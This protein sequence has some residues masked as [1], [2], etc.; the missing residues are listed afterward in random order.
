MTWIGMPKNPMKHLGF[1]YKIT[2]ISDGKFYIGKKLFWFKKGKK[3][4]PSDWKTYYGSSKDLIADVNEKGKQAFR[5]EVIRCYDTKW[6]LM[7]Y[8]LIEQLKHDVMNN[9]TNTFNG[10]INVRLRKRK[11]GTNPKVSPVLPR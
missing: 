6:D 7:Y 4:V 11:D 2:R 5:R 8:E 10:I 3:L 1:V 9:T